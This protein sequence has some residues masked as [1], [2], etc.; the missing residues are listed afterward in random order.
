MGEDQHPK[1]AR[2]AEQSADVPASIALPQLEVKVKVSL[3]LPALKHLCFLVL[4]FVC[5]F[6][7]G[8]RDVLH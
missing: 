5:L 7:S 6:V 3:A 2:L 8:G 1:R 4:V